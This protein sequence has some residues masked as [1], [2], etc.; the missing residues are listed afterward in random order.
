MCLDRVALLTLC[1]SSARTHAPVTETRPI[2]AR[3]Q[4]RGKILMSELNSRQGKR[5]QLESW[6]A[7]IKARIWNPL[8]L[9][10]KARA[11]LNGVQSLGCSWR[12]FNIRHTA[13]M[14]YVH[15]IYFPSGCLFI[16]SNTYAVMG[17]QWF[18]LQAVCTALASVFTAV[19]FSVPL[20]KSQETRTGLKRTNA[21]FLYRRLSYL[22]LTAYF[23]NVDAA[24]LIYLLLRWMVWNLRYDLRYNSYSLV[25]LFFFPSLVMLVNRKWWSPLPGRLLNG[26]CLT[27]C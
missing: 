7:G 14:R 26:K 11:E 20:R 24:C 8:L 18:C 3:V 16:D 17:I 5:R 21:Y 23:N 10:L 4:R 12:G 19:A 22:S 6:S 1:C 27:K 25:S 9:W 2:L 15:R 13:C